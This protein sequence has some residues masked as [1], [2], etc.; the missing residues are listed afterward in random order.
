MILRGLVQLLMNYVQ[1]PVV[2]A[3][4]KMS[5]VYVKVTVLPVQIVQALLMVMPKKIV[6]EP[7]MVML[8]RIALEHV[9]I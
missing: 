3:L 5:A 7:V 1:L 9:L 4:K 8:S 6:L 2:H